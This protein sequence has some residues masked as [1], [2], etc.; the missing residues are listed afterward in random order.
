MLF[1]I[2]NLFIIRRE[3]EGEFLLPAGC[4]VPK[5]H[6]ADKSLGNPKS[7]DVHRCSWVFG[8][9]RFGV[10]HNYAAIIDHF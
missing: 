7:L 1:S 10:T 2:V 8:V 4:F 5:L 3:G 9:Y 6:R